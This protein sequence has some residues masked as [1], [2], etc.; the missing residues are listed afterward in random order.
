MTL[1]VF[2]LAG[3][4][5]GQARFLSVAR[6]TKSAATE[7]LH[8]RCFG[9]SIGRWYWQYQGIANT[10][11]QLFASQASVLMSS[12]GRIQSES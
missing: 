8:P 12:V 7:R 5:G 10:I 1:I 11:V 6:P 9:E 4:R 3:E 2:L